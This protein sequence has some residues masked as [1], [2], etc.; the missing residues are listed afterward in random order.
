[1]DRSELRVASPESGSRSARYESLDVWRALVCLFVVT[2]HAAVA[3]W[4]GSNAS[5]GSWDWSLESLILLPFLFNVGTPLFFVMS[6]YCIAASLVSHRKRGGHPLAFLGRRLWRVFPP[7]WFAL[8]G[9]LLLMAGLDLAGL[10][11]LHKS[12]YGLELGTAAELDLSQWLGNLT[13]TET[14][15]PHLAGGQVNVITR[16]AWSLCYQEQFYFV[17]FLALLFTRTSLVRFLALA[18]VAIVGYYV[19]AMD[20]GWASHLTGTFP[21]LWH[22]FAIGLAVFWRLNLAPREATKFVVDAGLV[23]LLLLGIQLGQ[24]SV[25]AASCFGLALIGFHRYDLAWSAQCWLTPLRSLG[26]CSY[27]IYLTHLPFV[28]ITA[29]VL[30]EVGVT[31]FWGRALLTVPASVGVALALGML[32]SRHIESRFAGTLRFTRSAVTQNSTDQEAS[33]QVREVAPLAIA[34]RGDP[35]HSQLQLGVA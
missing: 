6:G 4:H 23:A 16:V 7:Y 30:A 11:R 3:L 20:F 2:E 12:P 5:P 13:L 24:A 29:A 21:T 8:L 18:S 28:V 27:G 32:F 31:G 35:V 10:E 26:R 14:W 9:F 1:M 22:E 19:V 17:C 34:K 33:G 25:I 15:R